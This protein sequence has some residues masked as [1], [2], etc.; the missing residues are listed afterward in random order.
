MSQWTGISDFLVNCPFNLV[1]S[2]CKKREKP[3]GSLT[4]PSLT[5]LGVSGC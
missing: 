1:P 3:T 4:T 2:T 5:V